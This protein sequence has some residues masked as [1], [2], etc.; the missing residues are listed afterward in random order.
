MKAQARYH[1]RR[2]QRQYTSNPFPRSPASSADAENEAAP[3]AVAQN[4][5]GLRRRR[6][7][8][9][10]GAVAQSGTYG[11]QGHWWSRRTV[12][13]GQRMAVWDARGRVRVVDGPA[14]PLLI[15]VTSEFLRHFRADAQHYLCVKR[16]DGTVE[17]M[18]GPCGLYFDPLRH[19]AVSVC[20]A[21]NLNNDEACAGA[22]LGGWAWPYPRRRRAGGAALGGGGGG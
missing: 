19:E 22:S 21:I 16:T 5:G 20:H 11:A 4:F 6:G 18:P 10:P 9:S 12:R 3:A 7:P 17:H 14:R 13:E 2:E 1:N 15:G 8:Q